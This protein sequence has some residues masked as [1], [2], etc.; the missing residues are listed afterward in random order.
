VDRAYLRTGGR[1]AKAR[2][3]FCVNPAVQKPAAATTPCGKVSAAFGG[4][5]P[6][7]GEDVFSSWNIFGFTTS[8]KVKVKARGIWLVLQRA[9]AKSQ[10]WGVPRREKRR[11]S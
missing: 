11:R 2:R 8:E 7:L 4:E 9:L 6:G 5:K 10:T 1:S 3:T